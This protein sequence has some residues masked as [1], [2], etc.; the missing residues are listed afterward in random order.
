VPILPPVAD[1][2]P[3]VDVQSVVEGHNVSVHMNYSAQVAGP[4][5]RGSK[6]IT[7]KAKLISIDIIVLE[8]ISR[9]AFIKSFLAIHELEDKF[10]A[11][12]I[13]GP[14]FKMSWTGSV[15]VSFHSFVFVIC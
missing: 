6:L 7:K 11:G 12:A 13:S 15:Y 1:V 9:V 5:S 10:A 3:I 8:D 2:P 4:I 14:P